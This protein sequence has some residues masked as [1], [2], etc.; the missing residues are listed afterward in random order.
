[1]RERPGP[2]LRRAYGC[3][4]PP[5]TSAIGPIL[6]R[7]D[8][9]TRNGPSCSAWS[10]PPGRSSTPAS[11]TASISRPRRWVRR[12]DELCHAP[13]RRAPR[14]SHAARRSVRGADTHRLR[15]ARRDIVDL[16]SRHA[17]R[18]RGSSGARGRRGAQRRYAWSSPGGRTPGRARPPR[19]HLPRRRARSGRGRTAARLPEEAAAAGIR[20]T[21]LAGG[22][23]EREG[24]G[25]QPHCSRVGPAADGGLRVQRPLRA[26]RPG[27]ADPGGSAVPEEVSVVGFDDSPLAG[28]AHVD[29][30]TVG[31]DSPG[32]GRDGG[33]AGGR[34]AGGPSGGVAGRGSGARAEAGRPRIDCAAAPPRLTH[35]RP[36]RQRGW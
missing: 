34:T 20:Q 27:R 12:G 32:S 33:A 35:L 5:T 23:T 15:I 1:M 19:C 21:M 24:A 14:G 22:L 16:D 18:G 6:V 10:S 26:G 13:P 36:S 30:T 28:L 29:L 9:A 31:Q 11:S 8:V 4:R 2:V 25:R 3:A 17:G 7:A